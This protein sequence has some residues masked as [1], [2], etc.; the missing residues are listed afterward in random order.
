MKQSNLF[1]SFVLFSFLALSSLVF[2]PHST[3]TAGSGDEPASL[4]KTLANLPGL[5]PAMGASEPRVIPT[6]GDDAMYHQSWFLNSFLNLKEDF[7]AAKAEGKRFVVVFEQR[8]CVY[9]VKFHTKTL[10]K[11]YINDYIRKNFAVVQLNMWGDR[12]VVDFD[13][14]TV[15]EKQLAARWGAIFTPT[16]VFLKDDLT[17]L[18]GKFGPPI[19][20]ARLNQVGAGTVYDMFVWIKHKVYKKE[21]NFQRFHIER[22]N[23]RRAM[24][25]EKLGTDGRAL[26]PIKT[27]G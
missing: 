18:D 1:R 10:A 12:E 14:K 3:A 27:P 25:G 4:N 13:G 26:K 21:R 17:G 20:V 24:R 23:Q 11:K 7:A 6:K 19:E 16:I 9:C 15:T 2:A 8:G 5:P 22:I